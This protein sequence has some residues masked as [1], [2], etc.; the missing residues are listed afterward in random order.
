[1]TKGRPG[2]CGWDVAQASDAL[3]SSLKVL[4]VALHEQSD[5]KSEQTQNGGEDLDGK[6]LDETR[7]WLASDQPVAEDS[8]LQSRVGSVSQ[9]SATSV[10]AY[11]DTANEVAH[12]NGDSSPEQ[13]VS[14]E[15][16]GARV[17]QL[18]VGEL[19]HLGGEDDGHDDAVD[20]DDFAEDD[21]DQVLGSYPRC[22]DTSTDD[23]HTGGPDSPLRLS[24]AMHV[25]IYPS[26]KT[27][28]A[29]PTTERPMHSAIPTLAQVYGDTVSRKA[30]T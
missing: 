23:G 7:V 19:V 9:S 30:P 13:G 10:D 8:N 5:D 21:G 25:C 29:D 3:P 17:K 14:S 24:D 2:A 22:L 27:Y 28:H 6:N 26:L 1:M 11:A 18:G 16:V 4:G 12:A 20:G 15:V